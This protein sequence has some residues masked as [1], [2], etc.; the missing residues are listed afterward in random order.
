M[1]RFTSHL[2]KMRL[3]SL[4][5]LTTVWVVLWGRPSWG[6]VL[7]GL[8]VALL[9]VLLFPMPRAASRIRFRP[10]SLLRLVAFFLYDLLRASLQ[11]AWLAIRPRPIE[12]GRIAAVQL[13]ETDDFRRTIIAELT[14]L[15]PGTVVIDLD[16]A[17]NELV[18]HVLDRCDDER[19][20][21]EVTAIHRREQLVARAFGAPA[22]PGC[23]ER[24]SMSEVR[25]VEAGP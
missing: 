16:P 9:V 6:T 21:I 4:L 10:L 24:L 19:L 15:V 12:H 7:F 20:L 13:H 2:A 1:S 11:V 17:S 22:P 23:G 14:S 25:D 5:V 8:L 3:G 18:I